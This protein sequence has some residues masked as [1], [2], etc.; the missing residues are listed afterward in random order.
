MLATKLAEQVLAYAAKRATNTYDEADI[1]KNLPDWQ[2][3]AGRASK[4]VIR[5]AVENILNLS[6]AQRKK[7]WQAVS[8]DIEFYKHLDDPKFEFLY[9]KL[10][11]ATKAAGNEL[12]LQFYKILGS[13]S[14]FSKLVGQK[15]KM[16]GAILEIR[17]GKDNKKFC[18][19][20]LV[21][22]L[23][24]P[25]AGTSQNDREHYFPQSIYPP[26]AVHPFNLAI[27]CIR[28]NQRRHSDTDPI[29]DHKAGALLDS[30]LPY[31][32]PGLDQIEL[33]FTL[34]STRA[35]VKISGKPGMVRATERAINFDRVYRLSEYWSD[36]LE[37]VDETL[38]DQVRHRSPTLTLANTKKV[39]EEML[40]VDEQTKT[41][42]PE[43]FLRGQYTSWIL[44]E[45]L[46][47]WFESFTT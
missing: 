3:L 41:S 28:C 11:D 22:R 16:N 42:A 29:F 4:S 44:N 39:L 25:V 23:P 43:A 13:K 14:G 34:G 1:K 19:A 12:L 20:C 32:R 15:E 24:P 30:F 27:S 26:L 36:F 5:K 38:R 40:F 21:E 35:M 47:R 9:R 8:N 18:P 10:P 45:R 33:Q 6:Q 17:Y 7:L 37:F 31:T 46:T 2:R